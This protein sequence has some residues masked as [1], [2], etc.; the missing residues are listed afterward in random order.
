MLDVDVSAVLELGRHLLDGEDHCPN[1]SE[2]S[3]VG[4]QGVGDRRAGL[5]RRQLTAQHISDV[6]RIASHFGMAFELDGGVIGRGDA[7]A[8]VLIADRLPARRDE[9]PVAG[10]G[11][12]RSGIGLERVEDRIRLGEMGE[13][14][15]AVQKPF[16]T[17]CVGTTTGYSKL[18]PGAMK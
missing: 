10:D 2:S 4:H 11:Q 7:E 5:E 8:S 14:L 15:E 1:A 13:D 9:G 6:G 17:N 16:S 18:T 3:E 12:H